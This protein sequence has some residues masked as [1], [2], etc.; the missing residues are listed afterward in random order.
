MCRCILLFRMCCVSIK[1]FGFIHHTSV[2]NIPGKGMCL[3]KTLLIQG[4]GKIVNDSSK[5]FQNSKPCHVYAL[6]YSCYILSMYD[7]W[8]K[9]GQYWQNSWSGSANLQGSLK[10]VSLVWRTDK[11]WILCF[12]W[13]N[14]EMKFKQATC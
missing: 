2:L 7:L 14:N 9:P 11:C 6:L 13:N 4:C 1:E 5:S 12:L 3:Q 10:V 8:N